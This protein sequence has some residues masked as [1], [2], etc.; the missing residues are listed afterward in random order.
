MKVVNS[1]GS[2]LGLIANPEQAN[3]VH[4]FSKLRRGKCTPTD[5]DGMLEF[6]S[7]T[8]VFWEFKH[9]RNPFI[10]DGQRIAIEQ[11]C[12]VVSNSRP[13]IIFHC[14]HEIE[15]PAPI[16]CGPVPVH[17]YYR[18]G[19]WITPS[20]EISAAQALKVWLDNM[21]RGR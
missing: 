12:D 8:F 20:I 7:Q 5:I 15:A 14:I 18:S 19:K 1:H 6:H 21:N 10:P 9:W 3:Q 11:L 16:D 17:R 4:D 13:S 2:L